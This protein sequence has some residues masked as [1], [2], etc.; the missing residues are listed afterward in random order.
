MAS[1]KTTVGQALAAATARPFV[2]CDEE[3]TRRHGATAAEIAAAAGV[4]K[5]HEI[6]ADVLLDA[7][8]A[9]DASVITAAA[10]TIEVER[11][12]VA[13]MPQFVVWM[14]ADADVLA[15]RV[16]EKGHRPLD[17]DVAAQLRTQAERRDPLFAAA[18][19]LVVDGNDFDAAAVVG[20]ITERLGHHSTSE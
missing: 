13:L 9:S 6:E 19:G 15:T 8:A 7:V 14:R 20:L 3:L 2:D 17:D 16:R 10:S 5:L 18:A 4:D 12:R 11:C 1:G